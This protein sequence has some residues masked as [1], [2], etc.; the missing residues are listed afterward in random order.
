MLVVYDR[1]THRVFSL[2]PLLPRAD[3]V[4]HQP[5]PE[6]A[7]LLRTPEL[8]VRKVE[9]LAPGPVEKKT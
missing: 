6:Q 3:D 2:L 1:K 7:R 9:D 4:L 5:L 8:V